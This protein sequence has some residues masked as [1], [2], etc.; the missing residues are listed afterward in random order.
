MFWTT[1]VAY[2]HVF[3]WPSYGYHNKYLFQYSTDSDTP[4][5]STR[6]R[7]TSTRRAR[8]RRDVIDLD[9]ERRLQEL[10]DVRNTELLTKLKITGAQ[11]K[12]DIILVIMLR[13]PGHLF[14]VVTLYDTERPRLPHEGGLHWCI[15]TNCWEMDS[16]LERLCCC[17]RPLIVIRMAHMQY[18][19]LDLGVRRLARDAWNDVFAVDDAQE[20]VVEQ[21]QYRHTDYPQFVLWQHGRPEV[22]NRVVIPSCSVWRIRE[23]LPDPIGQ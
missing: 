10:Q 13:L 11:K 19:I 21:R 16:D 20:P 1:V 4:W 5:A 7:K 12:D 15:C 17:Q 22:G 14:D 8:R 6:A 2:L 23:T 9:R 18:Y 3:V